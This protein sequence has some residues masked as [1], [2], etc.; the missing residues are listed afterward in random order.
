MTRS[1]DD[2]LQRVLTGELSSDSPEVVKACDEDEEFRQELESLGGLSDS[3]EAMKRQEHEILGS[4]ERTEEGRAKAERM[5]EPLWTP[6]SRPVGGAA[7]II[8]ILALAAAAAVI[9][10]IVI[11]P[12]GQTGV[13]PQA[14]EWMGQEVEIRT[15]EGK[16]QSFDLFAW[17]FDLP[18]GSYSITVLNASSGETVVEDLLLAGTQWKPDSGQIEEMGSS[19][20]WWVRALR[21][22]GASVIAQGSAHAER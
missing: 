12:G 17:D 15:P 14:P 2:L 21:P 4:L 16:N 13:E 9:I 3:L 10:W 7:K 5:L 18:R 19:I 11:N 8:P 22:D 1:R 6:K 20:V